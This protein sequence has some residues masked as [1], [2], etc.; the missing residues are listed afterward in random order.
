M[1]VRIV[2]TAIVTWLETSGGSNQKTD[3][4]MTTIRSSGKKTFHR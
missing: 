2:V 1:I 4:D 3:H